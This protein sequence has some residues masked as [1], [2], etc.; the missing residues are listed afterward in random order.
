MR[1]GARTLHYTRFMGADPRLLTFSLVSLALVGCVSRT[2]QRHYQLTPQALTPPMVKS[3]PKVKQVAG[4]RFSRT[5]CEI[6]EGPLALRWVGRD[7]VLRMA[8]DPTDRQLDAFRRGVAALEDSGC[9]ARDGAGRVLDAVAS[10]LALPSGRIYFARYGTFKRSASIDLNSNFRLKAVGP[11][12]APGVTDLKVESTIPD[13]PGAINVKAGPGLAGYET[14]Y[15]ELR[16]FGGG[17]LQIALISA[18]QT[19]EGKTVAVS[20]PEGILPS[21]PP[22][23]RCVRLLFMRGEAGV[24]RYIMLLAG[25]KYME[26]EGATGRIEAAGDSPGACR[27][28]RHAF[29]HLVPRLSAV[30]PELRVTVNGKPVYV[31]IGGTLSEALRAGGLDKPDEQRQALAG[32]L[33]VLRPW[34]ENLIPV[35][36]ADSPDAMLGLVPIGGEQIGLSRPRPGYTQ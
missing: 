1:R 11:L 10:S 5:V 33:Q 36:A 8:P 20:R 30:T 18:E 29:C 4:P 12:L 27:A 16:P 24:I 31:G 34:R 26:L 25:S 21:L 3:V 15:Y 7:A 22:D 19:R 2:V 13:R 6:E 17:G 32:G 35:E 9:L 23:A 14:S 28:E